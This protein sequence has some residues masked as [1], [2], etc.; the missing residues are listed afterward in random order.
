MV[1]VIVAAIQVLFLIVPGLYCLPVLAIESDGPIHELA[2][3]GV[4]ERA[5]GVDVDG[6]PRAV[7][8]GPPRH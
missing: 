7:G 8:A 2:D 5:V 6:G 1:K 3:E 4:D